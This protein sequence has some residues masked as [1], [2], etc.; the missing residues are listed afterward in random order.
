MPAETLIQMIEATFK[1]FGAL[2]NWHKDPDG[3]QA[4]SD[5]KDK[6]IQDLEA[7]SAEPT[8]SD[9]QELCREWRAQRIEL[10]GET[11]YPPDMFIES[12]CQVIEIS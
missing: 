5:V 8:K 12:V 10:E 11:T 2:G 9:L 1:Y 6:I 7:F 3:V 4:V